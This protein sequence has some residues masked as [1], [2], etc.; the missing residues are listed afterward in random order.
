MSELAH[1][2]SK[3][4]EAPSRRELWGVVLEYYLSNGF[5][6]ISYHSANAKT[7]ED[8]I[9]THGFPDE[10]VCHYIGDHLEK[11]DPIPDL[12]NALSYPFRWSEA[13]TLS[14]LSKENLAYL[15]ELDASGIGDGLAFCVF[16]PKLR[17]AYVGLGFETRDNPPTSDEI[18][19]FQLVAQLGHLQYC[20][21]TDER[22]LGRSRLSAR[23][24]QVL[25]WVA[26]G[27]SNGVIGEIMGI[28]P[29]TV[30]S[31]MRRIYEKL[32]VADR[33]TAAIKALGSGLLQYHDI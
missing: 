32:G 8:G 22:P 26:R 15:D 33:T 18:I 19:E 12:A 11:I 17:N 14:K 3:I 25:E 20:K 27:K 23:E 10:W 7:G 31:M 13:R 16:G 30:D 5:D 9:V 28:S 21:L 6:K 4:K 1:L 29:H 2:L 24:K